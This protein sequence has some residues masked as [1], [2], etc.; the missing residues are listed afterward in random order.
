[1]EIGG[2]FANRGIN[3]ELALRSHPF[4]AAKESEGKARGNLKSF[5]PVE[6]SFRKGLGNQLRTSLTGGNQREVGR[7]SQDRAVRHGA[8]MVLPER[9]PLDTIKEGRKSL[10]VAILDGDRKSGKE[11]LRIS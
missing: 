9:Q 2:N 6:P 8:V 10:V 7:L 11:P 3:Q 5:K 1:M 4:P